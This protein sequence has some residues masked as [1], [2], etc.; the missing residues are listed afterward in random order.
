MVA[1][2]TK[3]CTTPLGPEEH[4]Q[5]IATTERVGEDGFGCSFTQMIPICKKGGGFC[6]GICKIGVELAAGSLRKWVNFAAGSAK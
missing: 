4:R 5:G 3:R 6:S 1:N 2:A